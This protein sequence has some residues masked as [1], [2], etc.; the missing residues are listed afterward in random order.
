MFAK[1]VIYIVPGAWQLP[2]V[3]ATFVTTAKKAGYPVTFNQLPTVGG[4]ELPL[5]AL[6]DDVAVVQNNLQKLVNEEEREVILVGH[7]SGGLVASCAAEGFDAADRTYLHEA[8]S[9]GILLNDL[10]EEERKYLGQQ[11][12]HTSLGLFSTPSTFEPWSNGVPCSYIYCERDNAICMSDQRAM[13][14]RLGPDAK[15]VSID[16][17]HCPYLSMPKDLLRAIEELLA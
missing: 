6:P 1:P 14:D 8:P 2:T 9:I 5:A 4:T 16:S 15:E 17:G 13:R 11:I 10:P 3:W 12:T 7:S